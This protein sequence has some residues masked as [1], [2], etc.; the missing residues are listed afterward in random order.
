VTEILPPAGADFGDRV[1]R[2]LRE[3]RVIWLTTTSADGTP[4][5]NPVWF[6]WQAPRQVLVFSLVNAARLRHV[7]ARPRVSLNLNSDGGG[8]IIVLAGT[9]RLAPEIPPPHK[10]DAYVAK[11][12][13]DMI[14]ICKTLEAFTERYGAAIEITIKKVRGR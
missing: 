7:A 13:R 11:Y 5:P 14:R 10:H 4:Q 1:R 3:E 12:E 9:A 8:N 2:R 6:L